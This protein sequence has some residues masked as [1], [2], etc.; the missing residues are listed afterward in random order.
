[1]LVRQSARGKPSWLSAIMPI[2]KLE[3]LQNVNKVQTADKTIKALCLSAYQ[4]KFTMCCLCQRRSVLSVRQLPLE[5]KYD[6][7][8]TLPYS[9]S[10]KCISQFLF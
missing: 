8:K 10:T 4:V 9:N 3:T 1:M 6:E 5:N 2:S 7:S